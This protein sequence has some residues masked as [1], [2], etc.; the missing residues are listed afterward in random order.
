ML[1]R[2]LVVTICLITGIALATVG[3]TVSAKPECRTI[4]GRLDSVAAD[5]D[6]NTATLET[7][8]TLRGGIHA[9]FE[10]RGF[11]L[12]PSDVPLPAQYYRATSA[13]TLRDG[14]IVT[15]INTGVFDGM[16]GEV[17]EFTTFTAKDGIK[18][19]A[20]LFQ[21]HLTL[22]RGSARAATAGMS[23]FSMQTHAD[24]RHR[25]RVNTTLANFFVTY[26]A[27]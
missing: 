27:A 12:I 3:S 10:F 24:K 14:S 15:G 18:G 20:S 19:A 23:A 5:L 9:D 16:T 13:Y 2:P 8:G 7:V 1:T 26:I 6:G 21:G 11:T 17:T 22:L 4:H 25:G